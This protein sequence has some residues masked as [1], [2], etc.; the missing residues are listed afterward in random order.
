MAAEA[1]IGCSG[2]LYDGWRGRFYPDGLPKRRWFDHYADRFDTV[3]LN[4]TFYRLPDVDT[5]ERWRDRAPRGFVYASKLGQYG[6]HRKKLKDP[7]QWLANAL[8]RVDRLGRHR[9]PTLVQMPPNWRRDVDRLD[10]FLAEAT[11]H[12]RRW[13]VEFRDRSWLHDDTFAALARH[14]AALCIHDL[15]DDHPFEV[16]TDW[17]YVR[18]HGPH[19]TRTPYVGRYDGRRLR[20]DAERYARLLDEGCDVYAYF[21]N[22]IDADAPVD[23]RRLRGK[24]RGSPRSP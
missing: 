18:Y 21:N 12:G 14:G 10:A 8:D 13:A 9:G 15:L 11:G 6:S 4:A 5:V 3:E 24:I 1:R 7:D 20:A 2:Y 16:T 17:I 19:A 22:D 23:A